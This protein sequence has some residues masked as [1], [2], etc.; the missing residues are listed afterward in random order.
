[1]LTQND[2]F[3]RSPAPAASRPDQCL[4][5]LVAQVIQQPA[6]ACALAVLGNKLPVTAAWLPHAVCMRRR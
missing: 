5:V 2:N 6:R 3:T 1:M 4:L